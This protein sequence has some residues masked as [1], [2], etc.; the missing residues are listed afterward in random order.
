MNNVENKIKHAFYDALKSIDESIDLNVEDIVIEIPKDTSKGDYATNVA[1]KYAKVLKNSPINI[2]QAIIDKIDMGSADIESV[3][4]AGPGF[5]NIK[6]DQASIANVLVDIVAKGKD[7][8]QW[9]FDKPDLINVEYVSANPTGDLHLG[10]ARQ[11]SLG[12]S[13]TRLYKKAGYNIVREYYINDA[14]NQI[15][16]LAKSVI[17]RYHELFDVKMDMPEDGYFGQDIIDI[18]KMIQSIDGDKYVNNIDDHAFKYFKET[19]KSFEL[20]KI[21][22]DLAK[23]RVEFDVWTSEQKLYDEGKVDQAIALLEEKKAT[24]EKEGALWLETTKYGDDKDRVLRKSDGSLTYLT[25]DIAN[26]IQKINNGAKK[27]IDLWGA[28]HH[29]Y[30]KR[31]NAA[32][33]FCTGQSDIFEVD[34]VQLVRL[35]EDGLEVKM[36]KRSGKAIGMMELA[37][38]VGVD[39]VRYF[40]A[41]RAGSSHFD[42]DLT[43]AKSKSNENP[44]FYV[45]Y[46]HARIVSI[47]TLAKELKLDDNIDLSLLKEEKEISIIKHLNEFVNVVADSAQ[48]R[49]PHKIINYIQKLASLFHSYYN[50]HKVIDQSNLE[51]TK[52]RV[53]LLD[54]TRITLANALE[55]VGVSAP[56]KM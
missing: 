18:A 1:M 6:M 16:N 48:A 12:D 4:I 49:A 34:I 50:E 23:F 42:F 22:R 8:G 40:F 41:A 28:D 30:I 27:M 43:L 7:Y 44:V 13:I 47:L 25:P 33:E 17:V 14:G 39:A 46:A 53:L 35:I 5:I 9:P 37:N 2:A 3:E 31:M 38:E 55:L 36:S 32:I 19:A 54:A 24:Y 10:H 52:A 15:D 26:H 45:Q 20:D 56:E 51:L 11:A 21:K 29:G